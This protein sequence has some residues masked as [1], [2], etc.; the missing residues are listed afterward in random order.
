MLWLL[1]FVPKIINILT[2]LE[3]ECIIGNV[4]SRS[5][6]RSLFFR[7]QLGGAYVSLTELAKRDGGG[8]KNVKPSWKLLRIDCLVGV[9]SRLAQLCDSVA[10]SN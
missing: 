4:V 9:Q 3:T 6:Y 2:L 7:L 5:H 1:G 8:E 10:T